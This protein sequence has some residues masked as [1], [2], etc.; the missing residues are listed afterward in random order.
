MAGYDERDWV[1]LRK[2]RYAELTDAATEAQR[3]NE[4]EKYVG[5]YH[6]YW[7]PYGVVDGHWHVGRLPGRRYA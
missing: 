2:R 7:C 6:V 3:M 5:E 4:S 1:C